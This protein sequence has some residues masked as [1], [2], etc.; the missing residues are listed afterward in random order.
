VVAEQAMIV[1]QQSYDD[2]T[3]VSDGLDRTDDNLI[4]IY[5]LTHNP[6]GTQLESFV[7]HAGDTA[8]GR[9]YRKGTTTRAAVI[10]DLYI[11]GC[12][13]FE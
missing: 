2:L 9:I 7:Y 8:V 13:L 6:S 5:T 4:T 12:A 11:E 10:N 3:S 1:L